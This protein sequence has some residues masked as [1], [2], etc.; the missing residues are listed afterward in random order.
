MGRIP[1]YISL[2]TA[3]VISILWLFP[4]L[5]I[6]ESPLYDYSTRSIQMDKGSSRIAVILLKNSDLTK[7]QTVLSPI[8]GKLVR[9]LNQ[10]M[11]SPRK[12]LLFD[13]FYPFGINKWNGADA[14]KKAI[15]D[16]R[17]TVVFSALS[18]SS[19]GGRE[20]NTLI[21]PSPVFAE[22]HPVGIANIPLATD[23]KAEYVHWDYRQIVP[24]I[25]EQSGIPA[26]IQK[27]QPS[28]STPKYKI[29]WAPLGVLPYLLYTGKYG[30]IDPDNIIPKG[31]AS[32]KH[33]TRG[34]SLRYPFIDRTQGYL[35]DFFP[36]YTVTEVLTNHLPPGQQKFEPLPKT[37]FKH[38]QYV[39]VGDARTIRQQQIA[40]PA[41]V[42]PSIFVDA[43]VLWDLLHAQFVHPVPESI[44][45]FSIVLLA[46]APLGFS[47]AREKLKKPGIYFYAGYL[48]F[49]T[50]F[51][52]LDFL[53]IRYVWGYN[54][55]LIFPVTAS[56]LSFTGIELHRS[57]TTEQEISKTVALLSRYLSPELAEGYR[58]N[59]TD[60]G[61]NGRT[62]EVTILFCDIRGFTS[63]AES[64]SPDQVL[65]YIKDYY[66]TVGLIIIEKGGF[67][68][69]FVGDEIMG[70]FSE[71]YPRPDD[72]DQALEA[73]LEILKAVKGKWKIGVGLNTGKVIWGELGFQ[74]KEE[75]TVIGDA[76]NVASRLQE[77]TKEYQVPLILS[78]NTYQ[79]IKK[80]KEKYH[81]LNLGE[82]DV[83]GKKE[84]ILIW[85][86]KE[87]G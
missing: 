36:T 60:L 38:A 80:A 39:F 52:L 64:T 17:G 19:G 1:F 41:G 30:K 81:F 43:V 77:L 23:G 78:D 82:T 13:Y 83:R 57:F 34:I 4:V 16:F 70:I 54:L 86:V 31:E 68:A 69:K 27:I 25:P 20:Q 67:L 21:S 35:G 28:K 8:W 66:N 29:H 45:I 10:E 26:F 72:S 75:L 56:L 14:F 40:T 11:K 50:A 61:L 5:R 18:W 63:V 32:I 47:Y 12:I 87:A 84:K 33:G 79:A 65:E 48:L 58:K 62:D 85:T 74:K 55:A 24:Q 9:K 49:L 7:N 46:F 37:E 51:I 6:V 76:V 22:N 15:K 44:Q 71:P 42:V 59:P 53:L 73:G 3:L 2:S